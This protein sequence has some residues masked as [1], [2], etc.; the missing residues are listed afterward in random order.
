MSRLS[1]FVNED[2]ALSNARQA[3]EA[4][5]SRFDSDGNGYL[6][7][8]EFPTGPF[9]IPAPF[10]VIDLDGDG[11]LYAKELAA[12]S[13]LRQAAYRGQVRARAADRRDAA[14][15]ALDVDGDGRLNAREIRRV[16]SRLEQLDRNQ[17]GRLQS[18]ELPGSMVV[19]FVRG[20]PQTDDLL[21]TVPPPFAVLQARRPSWF[22]GMDANADLEVSVREFVGSTNQF[23]KLD[24]D[25]DGFISVHELE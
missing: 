24:T 14:F 11:Q 20:N 10:E 3:S 16:P 19:G 25:G 4:Q 12:F 6:S 5:V 18:H 22:R 23:M 8:E 21:F 17:D 13:E 7:E 9:G 1:F 15:A 2:P